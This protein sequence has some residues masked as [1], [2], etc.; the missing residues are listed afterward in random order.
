MER[1][2]E[3]ELKDAFKAFDKDGSGYITAKEL[4]AA[5]K[6]MGGNVSDKDIQSMIDK[7]DKDKD[8]KVGFD[9]KKWKFGYYKSQVI[10]LNV[11]TIN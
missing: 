5:M 9:G 11:N 6:K 10:L 1:S 7:A 4:K 3:K 8:G 2:D